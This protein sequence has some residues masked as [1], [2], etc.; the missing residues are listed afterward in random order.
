MIIHIHTY[1]KKKKRKI[2][3]KNKIK[4][5]EKIAQENGLRWFNFVIDNSQNF[6]VNM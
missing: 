6:N 1:Q 3:H 5:L 4:V 2:I